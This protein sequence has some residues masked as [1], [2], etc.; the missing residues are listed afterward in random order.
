MY[1]AQVGLA[2]SRNSLSC[3]SLVLGLQAGAIMPDLIMLS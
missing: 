2:L 3:A 1:V